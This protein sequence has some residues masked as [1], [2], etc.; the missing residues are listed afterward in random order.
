MLDDLKLI[1]ERDA[2]DMLGFAEKQIGQLT[3]GL[4]LTGGIKPGDIQTIVYSAM[5]NSA[6]SALLVRD[7]LDLP[8]PFGVVRRYDL[9][10]YVNDKT[11]FIVSSFSGDTEEVLNTLQQAESRGA[12]IAVITHGG[13]LQ[14]IAEENDYLLALLPQSFSRLSLIHNI[15]ALL[16][17]LKRAGVVHDDFSPELERAATILNAAV[18]DWRADV[19]T[20]R[21]PAKQIAQELLGRSLVVYSGP[22]MYAAAYKWKI[23]F[24]EN[25]KQV[26]WV[27]QYPEWN[28]NELTGW[29]KQPTLKPYAVIEL[30]SSLEH[31]RVRKRFEVT[32]RLLS[33]MMPAPIVIDAKGETLLEQLLWAALFGDFVSIYLAL[34]NGL[35]PAPLKLAEKFKQAL[36]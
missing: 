21:N 34:L 35:N 25:A 33:G 28:H 7:W 30:R 11:L 13:R 31:S 17:I 20:S 15:R 8:I 1:Y 3:D 5:G 36:A 24:N 27:N 2:Q 29:S 10:A 18:V 32:K 4:E 9:P 12:R 26:A 6:L 22:K 14:Q 16:Q 19:A 23:N